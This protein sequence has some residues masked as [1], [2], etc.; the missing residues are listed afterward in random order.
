MCA[1]Y[2]VCPGLDMAAWAIGALVGELLYAKGMV[3]HGVEACV[4]GATNWCWLVPLSGGGPMGTKPAVEGNV[5]TEVLA[6][7][8]AASA[9]R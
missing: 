7:A 5:P 1:E 8:A 6:L 2:A 3:L 4:V 9:K